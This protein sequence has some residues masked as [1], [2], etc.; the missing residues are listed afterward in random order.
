MS[1]QVCEAG[2]PA[3]W[4]TEESMVLSI[5]E[6][7][8]YDD[9]S[10]RPEAKQIGCTKELVCRSRKSHRETM[11]ELFERQETKQLNRSVTHATFAQ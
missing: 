7:Y 4:D 3:P 11:K 9:G 2:F 10:F 8:L 1:R 6:D 5:E